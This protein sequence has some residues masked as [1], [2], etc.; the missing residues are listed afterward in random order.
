MTA[1]NVAQAGHHFKSLQMETTNYKAAYKRCMG[2]PSVSYFFKEVLEKYDSRDPV[3]AL[4]DAEMLVAAMRL[5]L[6]CPKP[7]HRINF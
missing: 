4:N 1:K 5:K 2:D 6:G 7:G 3:D